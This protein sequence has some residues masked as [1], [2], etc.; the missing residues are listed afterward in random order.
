MRH[1]SR[2]FTTEITQ[3]G[4]CSLSNLHPCSTPMNVRLPC[5][6]AVRHPFD[7]EL[8]SSSERANSRRGRRRNMSG[9]LPP[10]LPEAARCACSLGRAYGRVI[11][12]HRFIPHSSL[13]PLHK[14]TLRVPIPIATELS[15][16][17]RMSN[18]N[19]CYP[20]INL[21]L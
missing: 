6:A 13:V 4:T 15:I 10:S 20:R 16:S 7:L 5:R 19:T 8:L 12:I 21:G 17:L 14:L 3:E 2:I 18:E 1:A 9:R 11:G